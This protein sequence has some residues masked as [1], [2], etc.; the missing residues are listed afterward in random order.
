MSL[1]MGGLEI[2]RRVREVVEERRRWRCWDLC[3]GREREEECGGGG[4]G[5]GEK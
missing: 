2:V 1:R 5:F 4:G 3:F